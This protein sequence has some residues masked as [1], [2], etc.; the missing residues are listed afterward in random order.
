MD[1]EDFVRYFLEED[2]RDRL[3]RRLLLLLCCLGSDEEEK[4]FFIFSR[5]NIISF[6][7]FIGCRQA[8]LFRAMMSEFHENYRRPPLAFLW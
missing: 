3:F 8:D 4:D 7:S 6:S 2:D 5:G 1:D